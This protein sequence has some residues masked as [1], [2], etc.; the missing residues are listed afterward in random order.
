MDLQKFLLS[1][2]EA[3]LINLDISL[4]EV[5]SSNAFGMLQ[6]YVDPWDWW[7][8]NDFRFMVWPGRGR[9]DRTSEITSEIAGNLRNTINIAKDLR[10]TLGAIS[11]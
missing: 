10:E 5:V 2:G 3:R 8:G 1:A 4:K 9:F 6:D 11:R 7:C